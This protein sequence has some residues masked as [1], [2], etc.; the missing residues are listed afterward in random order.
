MWTVRL[1]GCVQGTVNPVPIELAAKALG[2]NS[3]ES[4]SAG[5]T[6]SHA[7]AST[8]RKHHF[9][10]LQR[11]KSGESPDARNHTTFLKCSHPNTRFYQNN[12]VVGRESV[13]RG[14]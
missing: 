14:W 4:A 10:I 13:A 7:T 2:M 12:T 11:T 6:G 3:G 5:D 1:L 8:T 9:N